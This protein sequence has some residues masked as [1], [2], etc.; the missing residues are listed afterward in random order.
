MMPVDHSFTRTD[1]YTMP[2]GSSELGSGRERNRI[3]MTNASAVRLVMNIATAAPAGTY[4]F[5]EYSADGA[6]WSALSSQTPICSGKGVYWSAWTST[7]PP[8]KGDYLV[9]LTVFNGGTVATKL[10][11]GQVHL[12]FR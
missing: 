4:A 9:R 3:D 12:Q 1:S 2:V 5:A 8:S 7:P 11:L 6:N 10:G